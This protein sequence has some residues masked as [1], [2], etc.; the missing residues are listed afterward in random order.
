[1]VP[2]THANFR[3][4]EKGNV[5]WFGGGADLTPYYVFREDAV[6]F[7]KT[8]ADVCDRHAPVADS[9]PCTNHSTTPLPCSQ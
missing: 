5:V 3:C 6:H 7:H 4:I 1:M 9:Y 8:F 2:T